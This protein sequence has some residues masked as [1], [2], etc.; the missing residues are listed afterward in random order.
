MSD[1]DAMAVGETTPDVPENDIP[2]LTAPETTE[3]VQEKEA[4]EQPQKMVPYD[5]LHEERQRRKEIQQEFQRVRAEQAQRDAIIEQ[6][7]AALTQVN[8]PQQPQVTLEE[9]P[10]RFLALQNA[11]IQQEM[12]ASRAQQEADRQAQWQAQQIQAFEQHVTTH[13][14]N[15]AK[16]TP[17]Y[18]D[19]INFAKENRVKQLQVL[20]YNDQQ[21][22]Q[23][24]QREA[25]H[26]AMNIARQGGNPA[27]AG[28]E[29]AK[30]LGYQPKPNAQQQLQ[31]TQ[32]GLEASKSLS[33]GGAKAG[34]GLTVDALAK[35]SN[36]EFD[37]Y[38]Q[39]HGWEKVAGG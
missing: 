4:T 16:Q 9:D 10:V 11:R 8:Q 25:A 3:P 20:G 21:A 29:Y 15:F 38:V 1:T 22:W 17:D 37:A 35:M 5:A 31:N 24:V 30:S 7:L 26:L 19:A 6:R 23:E 34:G 39:K 36:E 32:K 27:Q 12:Q 18:F 33:G 2:G 14:Q 28:Y 13:E